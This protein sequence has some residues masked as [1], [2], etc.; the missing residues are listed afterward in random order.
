MLSSSFILQQKAV[1]TR[2]YYAEIKN[3]LCKGNAL[4]AFYRVEGIYEQ[5]EVDSDLEDEP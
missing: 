5:I 4:K 3:K 2:R 1:Y